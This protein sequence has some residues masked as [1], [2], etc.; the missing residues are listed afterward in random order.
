MYAG[1]I[2]HLE[3]VCKIK[4]QSSSSTRN[5]L[6]YDLGRSEKFEK[7]VEWCA[8]EK[9]VTPDKI[10]CVFDGEIVLLSDTPD[11]LDLDDEACI[12]IQIAA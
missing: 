4:I 7:L 6:T 8:K 12:D 1:Q 11:S 3:E 10:K 2:E 5:C 9:N